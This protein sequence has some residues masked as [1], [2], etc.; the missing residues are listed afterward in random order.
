MP[1]FLGGAPGNL[2]PHLG[3]LGAL[4]RTDCAEQLVSNGILVVSLEPSL[5]LPA[6]PPR[7]SGPP[8]GRGQSWMG[9]LESQFL[10][11]LQPQGALGASGQGNKGLRSKNQG[12][13]G[14]E[15]LTGGV[16]VGGSLMSGPGGLP[17][18]R[19]TGGGWGPEG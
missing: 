13:G 7:A 1:G 11:R 2:D 14:W 16:Y 4:F 10:R 6:C 3:S 5:Q 12:A 15:P 8:G 17:L 19:S 9:S 18:A